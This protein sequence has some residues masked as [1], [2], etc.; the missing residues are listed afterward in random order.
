MV[1]KVSINFNN[2]PFFHW[3]ISEK[4]PPTKPPVKRPH[5]LVQYEDTSKKPKQEE[6]EQIDLISDIK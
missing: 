2:A 3:R 5:E 1:Y 6:D 4:K